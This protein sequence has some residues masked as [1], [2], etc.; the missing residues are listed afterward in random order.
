MTEDVE[1]PPIPPRIA[2]WLSAQEQADPDIR[3]FLYRS[4]RARREEKQSNP[5]DWT[6]AQ[7]AAWLAGDWRTFSRLRGYDD[8]EI[9]NFAEF[10][11]LAHLLDERYGDPERAPDFSASLDHAMWLEST[12]GGEE[13]ERPDTQDSIAD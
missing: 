12:V 11:R 5:D 3:E 7:S 1:F 10:I 2:A 8:A 6:E 9:A 4:D 13:E